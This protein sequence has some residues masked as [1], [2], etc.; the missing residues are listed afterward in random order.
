[1]G[2]QRVMQRFA[3]WHIWL[4][5]LVGFPILMWTVTGLVMVAKPIEEV[6]GNHLRMDVPERALPADT[7]IAVSLPVESTRPVRSV[8][9][10][11]ERGET[12]TRIAYMAGTTER[13]R[14]DGSPMG[15]LSEVEARLIVAEGIVG[16][17][18][19]AGTARFDA[20]DVPFDFRRPMPVWQVA[21]ADGT[22]VYVGTETG[23]I[24]AVRTQW[25]RTFDFVWG[26]H[27]MDLQT[28]ED[29]S[30][31][32]LILFAILSVIGAL[33]GCI[34]MFRRRKTRVVPK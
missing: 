6:R 5:W 17:E 10:Q 24:E 26:L 2:N 22:H 27:I 20:D 15:P 13:F 31:P 3:K 8:T 34:L 32:V 11:V 18:A 16:G 25:W 7:E 1:M 14:P 30:H 28:R 4:G 9:T 23:R 19:V 33:F 21:L 12:I 29:T